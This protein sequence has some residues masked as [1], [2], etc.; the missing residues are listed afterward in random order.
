MTFVS[1]LFLVYCNNIFHNIYS[2]HVEFT[3]Y[4]VLILSAYTELK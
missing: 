1:S 3:F 2:L 4:F